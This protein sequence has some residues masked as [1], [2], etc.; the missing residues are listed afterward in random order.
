MADSQQSDSSAYSV[1]LSSIFF[2]YFF[3]LTYWPSTCFRFSTGTS[4]FTSHSGLLLINFYSVLFFLE[5]ANIYTDNIICRLVVIWRCK[6]V[7]LRGILFSL[8]RCI[9]GFQICWIIN[10]YNNIYFK[11]LIYYIYSTMRMCL[12]ELCGILCSSE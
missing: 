2:L 12:I 9:M 1:F 6:K 10:K 4:A 5:G 11:L 3:I 7:P 8:L